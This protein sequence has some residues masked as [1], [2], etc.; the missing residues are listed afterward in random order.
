MTTK[1]AVLLI[2][3]GFGVVVASTCMWMNTR[4]WMSYL[5]DALFLTLW[6]VALVMA[7]VGYAAIVYIESETTEE[8]AARIIRQ[9]AQKIKQRKRKL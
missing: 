5:G 9:A 3:G 2:F 4:F 1:Q 7:C 8:K 6:G